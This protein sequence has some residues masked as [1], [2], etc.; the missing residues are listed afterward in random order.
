VEHETHRRLTKA[1]KGANY[2]I[3]DFTY[4]RIDD[5]A[6]RANHS[7]LSKAA[8]M[9][10]AKGNKEVINMHTL[11]TPLSKE[12][13]H[14]HNEIAAVLSIVPGL[15]HIYKGHWEAGLLWMFLGMPMAIWIGILFGLATAGI[16]LLFPIL[17]WVG[18]AWDAYNEKDRRHH[19]LTSQWAEDDESQD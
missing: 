19:H 1:H 8:R 14:A 11:S 9:V 10:T 18:L 2:G 16:G 6:L 15:G 12:E 13:K 5:G 4:R 17:C 7:G 3:P